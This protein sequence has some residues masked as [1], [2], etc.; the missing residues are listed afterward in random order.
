MLHG[1]FHQT[2]M[3]LNDVYILGICP[4]FN[5]QHTFVYIL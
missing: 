3:T 1:L 4:D 5:K 2:D